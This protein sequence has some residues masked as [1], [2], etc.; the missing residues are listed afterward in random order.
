MPGKDTWTD[1]Y[2]YRD[3]CASTQDLELSNFWSYAHP[4]AR[5]VGCTFAARVVGDVR[6]HWLDG[7]YSVRQPD[8]TVVRRRVET[9]LD[10]RRL[11]ASVFGLGD[12]PK[13]EDA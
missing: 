11:L 5:W 8:G 3:E 1:L 12:E 7:E 6:H 4:S 9:D 10:V 2:W 13:P